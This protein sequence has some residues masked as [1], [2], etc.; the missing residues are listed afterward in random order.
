MS[1]VALDQVKM[2][3]PEFRK[4]PFEFYARLRAEMPVY[5]TNLPDKTPVW[6]LSRYDDVVNLTKDPRFV[7]NKSNVPGMRVPWMPPALK[8]ITNSLVWADPPDHTRLRNLVH[9]AFTPKFIENMRERIQAI[10]D[11]L[12]DKAERKPTSMDLIDDFA[13]PL[14]VKVITEVL[15]IPEEDR[16]RFQ[17]WTKNAVDV[18]SAGSPMLMLPSML[19]FT[20]YIHGFIKMR[21]DNPRDDL[22][23]SLIKA[24]EAGDKLSMDELSAMIFVLLVAGHETTVNLFSLGTLELLTHPDQKALFMN[25]PSV[26]GSALEELLRYTTPVEL[27]TERYAA[28]AM[29][30]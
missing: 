13:L 4:H 8:T 29:T 25:D 24:E 1:A 17:K 10:C 6:L 9:K 19:M 26:R 7:K 28:E 21:R 20:R 15:G 2:F 27:L 16:H 14:P 23:S 12:L 5:R 3:E 18:S 30:L 22:V 11:D